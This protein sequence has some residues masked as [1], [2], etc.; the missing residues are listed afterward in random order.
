[1]EYLV[2]KE[3]FKMKNILII[4]FALSSMACKAQNVVK[5]TYTADDYAEDGVYYKDMDNDYNQLEGTWLY[6]DGTSS[7]TITLEK[8]VM[9]HIV[10]ETTNYYEDVLIGE[11]KY[12][13]DGIE[14]VNTLSN[15]DSN[16]DNHVKVYCAFSDPLVDAIG[17]SPKIIFRHY[18]VNGIE[19]IHVNLIP[20]GNVA[21]D[22][23]EEDSPDLE[24]Y[25]LPYGNYVL[26]KQ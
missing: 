15:L 22:V 20:G 6:T 18:T 16:Y 26:T 24:N 9:Q 12:V 7:L 1:M 10:T 2:I 25:R 8:K 5:S 21:Y 4:I 11:Y 3:T 14:E 17:S 13:E 19:K 23:N